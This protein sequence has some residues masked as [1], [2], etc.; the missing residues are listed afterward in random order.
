[1]NADWRNR[2]EVAVEAAQEA[3]RIA[4]KYYPDVDSAAFSARVEWKADQTASPW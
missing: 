2:Y 1:M 4:L 3:G